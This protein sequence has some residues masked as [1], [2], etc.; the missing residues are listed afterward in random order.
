MDGLLRLG[1]PAACWAQPKYS[2]GA[3]AVA[4][5]QQVSTTRVKQMLMMELTGLHMPTQHGA[6]GPP[7]L[8]ILHLHTSRLTVQLA[9]AALP[10]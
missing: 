5:E 6:Y 3:A 1:G 7:T 8:A 2:A 4:A 10:G 9:P